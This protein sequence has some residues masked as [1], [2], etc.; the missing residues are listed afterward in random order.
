MSSAYS[1]P[2]HCL[3]GEQQNISDV[4]EPLGCH[5]WGGGGGQPKPKLQNYVF[6]R[7]QNKWIFCGSILFSFTY[8]ITHKVYHGGFDRE[9]VENYIGT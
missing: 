1:L 5:N 3:F 6:I 7:Y 8:L 2:L 9:F 4:T